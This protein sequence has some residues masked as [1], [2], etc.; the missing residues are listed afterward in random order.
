MVDVTDRSDV[1]VR[2]GALEFCFAIFPFLLLALHCARCFGPFAFASGTYASENSASGPR[3]DFTARAPTSTRFQA[4]W[5]PSFLA[6][7]GKRPIRGA[8]TTE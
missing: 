3:A 6:L 5:T 2:L 4:Y 8:A 7:R 1:Y